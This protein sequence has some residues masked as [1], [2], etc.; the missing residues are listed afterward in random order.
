MLVAN[1]E[2]GQGTTVRFRLPIQSEVHEIAP[3]LEVE[4]FP[5]GLRFLVV[6][7]E[8][9][10]RDM[11]CAFLL[12]QGATVETAVN[13]L[14][15]IEKFH[16]NGFDLVITDR[17]MPEMNG[18]AMAEAIKEGLPRMPI[19]M[20]TGFGEMMNSGGERPAG[21]DVI[22]GKPVTPAALR[23]AVAALRA[24]YTSQA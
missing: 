6:D 13:G 11:V 4:P 14:D 24:E 15:G 2:V 10:V 8:Q 22:L 3:V 9:R 18:D 7:D 21:V 17:G 1:S 23:Q 19:I 20:L 16:Q 5:T 12:R